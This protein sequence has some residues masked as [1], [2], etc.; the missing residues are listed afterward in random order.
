MTSL[1]AGEKGWVADNS[2]CSSKSPLPPLCVCLS[3]VMCPLLCVQG[4][5]VEQVCK[6]LRNLHMV[7]NLSLEHS[8]SVSCEPS[9]SASNEIHVC[10]VSSPL[11]GRGEGVN[12]MLDLPNVGST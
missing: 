2:W 8:V 5:T 4:L 1:N 11:D 10:I 6:E 9:A 7:K 12:P 3:N